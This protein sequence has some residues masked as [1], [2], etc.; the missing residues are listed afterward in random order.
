MEVVFVLVVVLCVPCAL[1]DTTALWDPHPNPCVQVGI[2]ALQ[3]P[4]LRPSVQLGATV[5]AQQPSPSLAAIA[6][7]LLAV[8]SRSLKDDEMQVE[9][10]EWEEFSF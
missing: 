10:G 9:R 1:L 8:H 5:Q 3:E 4:R 6:G 2:T 7:S